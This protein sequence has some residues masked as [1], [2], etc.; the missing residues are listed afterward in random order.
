M[1]VRFENLESR[2]G[3]EKLLEMKENGIVEG[4]FIINNCDLKSTVIDN[5]S[6]MD[7]RDATRNFVYN[8]DVVSKNLCIDLR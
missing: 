6:N 1:K 7:S 8:L 2:N 3:C 5:R 4:I